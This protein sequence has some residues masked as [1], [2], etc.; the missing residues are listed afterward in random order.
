MLN[1][2]TVVSFFFGVFGILC[3]LVSF[4]VFVCLWIKK[5]IEN[6]DIKQRRVYPVPTSFLLDSFESVDGTLLGDV[7]DF[8]ITALGSKRNL[9]LLKGRVDNK[10]KKLIDYIEYY[11]IF[12]DENDIQMC[13]T[14]LMKRLSIAGLDRWSFEFDINFSG[15]E[16]SKIKTV[17]LKIMKL[18]FAQDREAI[19]KIKE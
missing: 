5:I 10:I 19:I 14:I 3:C 13:K 11:F 18:K 12:L 1:I 7:L 16:V 15:G 2:R 6:R 9:L 8:E 17:Y 4:C